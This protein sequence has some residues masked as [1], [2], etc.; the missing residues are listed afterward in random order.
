MSPRDDA[1]RGEG[2]RRRF[3][4]LLPPKAEVEI[5]DELAFHMEQRVRDFERRGMTPDEAR[6]AASARLGDAWSTA[7]SVLGRR[8]DGMGD[9]WDVIIE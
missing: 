3:G 4:R 8:P 7:V 5:D 1:P 6:R 9:E 2:P